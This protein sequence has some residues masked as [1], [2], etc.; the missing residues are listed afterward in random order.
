MMRWVVV[1]WLALAGCKDQGY[2]E[3]D[4]R[5]A[6]RIAGVWQGQVSP[7]WHYRFDAPLLRQWVEVAGTVV[8]VQDYVYG[9]RA[10]TLFASGT[11]GNR[12]W[13]LYF[14]SDTVVEVT[15]L[16]GPLQLAP[17]YLYRLD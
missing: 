5:D 16:G 9:T 17:M 3:P 12:M 13:R 2:L 14:V 11:G 7:W 10:D 15:V 4:P 6:S 8:T 1:G